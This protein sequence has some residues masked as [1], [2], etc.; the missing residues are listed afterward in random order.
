VPN[1]RER[2][3]GESLDGR[4]RL[5]IGLLGVVSLCHVTRQRRADVP[6]R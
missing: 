5:L 6:K 4:R 3:D 1:T 2:H